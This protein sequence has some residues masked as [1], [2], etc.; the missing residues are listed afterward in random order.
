MVQAELR[1]LTAGEVECPC[2]FPDL[3][4]AVRGMMSA[5]PSVSAARQVGVGPVQQAIAES[6]AAFRTSNGGYRQRNK[7][8]YVVAAHV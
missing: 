5:G 4:T 7:F 3:E 1:P 8:R 6:L 2:V